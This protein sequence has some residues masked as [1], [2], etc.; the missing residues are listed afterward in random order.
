VDE[1]ETEYEQDDYYQDAA[2]EL[3]GVEESV[4]EDIDEVEE[5]SFDV[6]LAVDQLYTVV[7]G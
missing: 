4:F 5:D 6:K 2:D 7:Y 3:L 1:F